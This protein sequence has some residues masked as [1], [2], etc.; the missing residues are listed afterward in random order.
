[1]AEVYT[2]GQW[3]VIAGKE[4]EFVDAWRDLAEWTSENIE[5]AGW[6]KLLQDGEQPNV[7]LSFGRWENLAAIQAWRSAD[8][9]AERIGNMRGM[10]E[11]FEAHISQLAAE[12]E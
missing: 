7:F 6:A 4:D 5:G 12:I 9:F 3:T 11:D 1:M 2:H 8:G 10:L